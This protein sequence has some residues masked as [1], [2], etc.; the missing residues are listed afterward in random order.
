MSVEAT[1]NA[2]KIRNDRGSIFGERDERGR[3]RERK[4]FR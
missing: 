3:R 2:M 4:R 1:S